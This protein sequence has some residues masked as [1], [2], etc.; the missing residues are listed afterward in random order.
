MDTKYDIRRMSNRGSLIIQA[1]PPIYHHIDHA[2]VP[3]G[4]YFMSRRRRKAR[5]G[6]W[7]KT[8]SRAIVMEVQNHHLRMKGGED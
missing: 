1:T 7:L 5:G 2:P 6:G 4:H 3:Q 8:W